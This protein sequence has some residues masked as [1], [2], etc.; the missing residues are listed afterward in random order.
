MSN[1]GGLTWSKPEPTELAASS[2]PA[3]LMQIPT[4]GDLLVVWNQAS[5]DEILAGLAR[6]RLSCA[7]SSDEGRTW[8]H[9]RNLES[10]DDVAYVEPPPIQIY[11]MVNWLDGYQQPIDRGRYHR[12][13]GPVRST[14]AAGTFVGEHAVICYDYGWR[15]DEAAGRMRLFGTKV[16][17]IPIDWFYRGPT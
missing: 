9:H 12:A 17:V 5:P 10:L 14:Y 15:P 16:K 11:Q 3:M 6:H 7:V 13:P 1:D 4:T 2:S 8:K